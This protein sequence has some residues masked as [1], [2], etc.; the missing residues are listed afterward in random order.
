MQS[1]IATQR[2]VIL[3]ISKQHIFIYLF[4]EQLTLYRNETLHKS[5]KMLKVFI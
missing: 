5:C 4:T 1:F 2:L 3:Y